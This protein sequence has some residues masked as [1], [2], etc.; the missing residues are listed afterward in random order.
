MSAGSPRG[1][2]IAGIP[3]NVAADANIAFGPRAT[4]EAIVHSGGNMMKSVIAEASAEAVK[5]IVSPSEYAVLRAQSETLED[6]T[7]SVTLADGSVFR[8]TGRI[9]LDPFQSDDSSVEVKMLTTTGAW[10]VFAQT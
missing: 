3:Y 8:T 5:L 6:I 10:D 7:L 4:W 2:T 9:N 1:A